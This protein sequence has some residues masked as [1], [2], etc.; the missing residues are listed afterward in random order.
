VQIQDISELKKAEKEAEQRKR[1]ISEVINS[2]DYPI[3]SID[4]DWNLI[5]INNSPTMNET[6]KAIGFDGCK[7][8]VGRNVLEIFSNY[9]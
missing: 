9:M 6:A 2:I 1:R 4:Y 8:L 7:D 3:Y 5:F